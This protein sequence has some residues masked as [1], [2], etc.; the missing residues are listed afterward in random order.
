MRENP[1]LGRFNWPYIVGAMIG[2]LGIVLAVY[3]YR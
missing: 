2:C 3:L 1:Y